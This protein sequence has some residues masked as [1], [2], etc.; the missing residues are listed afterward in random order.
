[1]CVCVLKGVPLK[2]IRALGYFHAL[3]CLFLVYGQIQMQRNLQKM[4]FQ[5]EPRSLGFD[6][7]SF[8]CVL[9]TTRLA[10]TVLFGGP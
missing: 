10:R 1:M 4:T 5:R 2:F 3:G 8:H 6:E 7:G 9:E